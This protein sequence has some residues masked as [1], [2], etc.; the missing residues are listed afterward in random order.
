M[1]GLEPAQITLLRPKRSASTISPH[2]RGMH[3]YTINIRLSA[4]EIMGSGT[5]N[6]TPYAQKTFRNTVSLNVFYFAICGVKCARPHY[7]LNVLTVTFVEIY[8]EFNVGDYLEAHGALEMRAEVAC[9]SFEENEGVLLAVFG[10]GREKYGHLAIVWCNGNVGDRDERVGICF[11]TDEL[12]NGRLQVCSDAHLARVGL[13]WC[14]R[15]RN[16]N[17]KRYKEVA[18]AHIDTSCNLHAKLARFDTLDIRFAL[19]EVFNNA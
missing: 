14:H 12:C 18:F 1:T 17:G 7:L 16:N 4:S 6:I 19:L 8:F 3:S 10:N 11:E 9:F 2:A 5:Y 15:L 13:L